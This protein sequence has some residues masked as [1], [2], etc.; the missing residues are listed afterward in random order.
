MAAVEGIVKINTNKSISLSEQQLVDC[1]EH[2]NG[3]EGGFPDYAFSYIKESEGIASESDYPYQGVAGICQTTQAAAQI[4]GYADVP[5]NSEELLLQAVAK[6][7]VSVGIAVDNNFKSYESDVFEGPCEGTD[8][9]HAVTI[10]G[11]GT[12]EDGKKYWLIKNSWGENWGESGYMRLLRDSEEAGAGGVC[13]IAR[14][15]S[16]PLME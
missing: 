10:V 4:T 2:S 3:C 8:L 6:Q 9:N 13:G 14:Q 16:Y 1:D 11:Y 5:E 7:P 12:T 15:A